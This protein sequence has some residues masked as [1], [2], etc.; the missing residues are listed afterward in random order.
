MKNNNVKVAVVSDNGTTVSQHFGSAQFF[1][2][3]TVDNGQIINKEKREK[4]H[5][6]TPGMHHHRQGDEISVAGSVNQDSISKNAGNRSNGHGMLHGFGNDSGNKHNAM[7]QNIS[8]CQYLVSRGM[9]YGI[10]QHLENA[11]IKPIVTDIRVIEDAV[12]AVIAG[13]IINHSEKLH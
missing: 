6:H 12:N 10:Y 2:V 8:D 13:T 1:Y 11:K 3:F 9:G 5:A 4:Y 7:I